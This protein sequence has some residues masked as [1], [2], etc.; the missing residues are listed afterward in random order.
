VVITLASGVELRVLHPLDVL[1]SHLQNLLLIPQKRHAVGIA[2]AHVAA[3]RIV[4]AFP[5]RRIE[6][7]ASV[8]EVLD[9]IECIGQ[10]ATNERLTGVLL[11]YDVDILSAVAIEKV[12][13]T[14]FRAKRWP[15]IARAVQ[16]T[17]Q[18][19]TVTRAS[20]KAPHALK[21]SAACQ[22]R[23]PVPSS[24]RPYHRAIDR[25]LGIWSI[26]PTVYCRAPVHQG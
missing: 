13:H 4:N 25:S 10:I 5:A 12:D 20:A 1:E 9:A 16:G 24:C 8:R 19:S 14:N 15:Q 17:A 6:Q 7:C 21:A 23:A 3:V 18:V 22:R 2:Q 26:A 11:D